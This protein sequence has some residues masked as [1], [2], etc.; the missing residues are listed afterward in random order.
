MKP[1]IV[2]MMLFVFAIAGAQEK[3]EEQKLTLDKKASEQWT[4][5][6]IYTYSDSAGNRFTVI[7]DLK[8]MP[9]PLRQGN[10]IVQAADLFIFEG[11]NPLSNSSVMLLQN[12]SARHLE[13]L[14]SFKNALQGAATGQAVELTPE[15]AENVILTV[16][17]WLSDKKLKK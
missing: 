6:K 14:L 4:T 2:V 8:L 13:L 9:M 11:G 17:K 12:I 5:A 16:S 15:E 7:G 3:F 10:R 1:A